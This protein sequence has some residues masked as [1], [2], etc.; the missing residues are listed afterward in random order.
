VLQAQRLAAT[1]A[2][3]K[4]Q[5]HAA[6]A[7]GAGADVEGR[8]KRLAA[9]VRM[10]KERLGDAAAAAGSGSRSPGQVG[11]LGSYCIRIQ[12]C[13]FGHAATA[14]RCQAGIVAAQAYWL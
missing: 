6:G 4:M 2:L 13:C 12:A 11:M 7:A 8:L 9:D 3:I 14:S 10:L 1:E 5:P